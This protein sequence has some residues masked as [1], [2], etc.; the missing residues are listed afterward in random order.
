MSDPS[1]TALFIAAAAIVGVCA[2]F[3]VAWACLDR[4][5]CAAKRQ[6]AASSVSCACYDLQRRAYVSWLSLSRLRDAPLSSSGSERDESD[7]LSSAV[8]ADSSMAFLVGLPAY[9]K[10]DM[11][12]KDLGETYSVFKADADKAAAAL[13][14][15]KADGRRLYS[16]S[17]LSFGILETQLAQITDL[18]KQGS[19]SASED[20]ATAASA[21]FRDLAL[22]C[23][24]ILAVELAFAL[25]VRHSI[26]RPS[27]RDRSGGQSRGSP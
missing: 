23:L 15:G 11:K 9:G 16:S 6:T 7:Y 21:A 17:G 22:A 26:V 27:T 14:M 8:D 3:L 25:W 5:S 10:A 20:S 13:S 19:V 24:A 1:R 2:A 12:I 18:A 4:V